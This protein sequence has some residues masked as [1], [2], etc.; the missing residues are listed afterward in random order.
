M[1]HL[2]VS[3]THDKNDQVVLGLVSNEHYLHITGKYGENSMSL[4]RPTSRPRR[5]VSWV[6]IV[7]VSGLNPVDR[8][9]AAEISTDEFLRQYRSAVMER[10]KSEKA[11]HIEGVLTRTFTGPRQD[12]VNKKAQSEALDKEKIAP[13]AKDRI[14]SA[15]TVKS[16]IIYMRKDDHKIYHIMNLQRKDVDYLERVV[17][18]TS[19]DHGFLLRRQAP[20]GDFYLENGTPETSYKRWLT[21][22]EKPVVDAPYS[23]VTTLIEPILFSPS[24][25]IQKLDESRVDGKSLVTIQFTASLQSVPTQKTQVRSEFSGSIVVAPGNSHALTS[26]KVDVQITRSGKTVQTVSEQLDGHI[27]YK[28]DASTP[29]PTEIVST[30]VVNGRKTEY[31]F[32][33]TRWARD[34]LPPSTFTLAA[35]GLGEL[36]KPAVIASNRFSYWAIAVASIAFLSSVIFYRLGRR[37]APATQTS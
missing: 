4:I 19:P 6:F 15:K 2:G 17:I 22:F 18:I 1:S 28:D 23:L 12:G 31:R 21:D 33:P 10:A 27:A 30:E 29:I 11:L 13:T 7:L 8:L 26:Y 36:E 3:N 34:D 16:T 37:T 14:E 24:F 25:R 9:G 20:N 5:V 35:Y 32:E